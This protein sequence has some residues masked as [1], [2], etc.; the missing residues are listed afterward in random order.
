MKS[1]PI[2]FSGPMV[3]AILEG[4]K[5]QTRRIV[6]PQPE[7][8]YSL[9]DDRLCVIHN[10]HE[11]K[12]WSDVET[13]TSFPEQRLHGGR[14]WSDLFTDAICGLREKGLRGLV[15]IGRSQRNQRIFNGFVVP[16][17][18]ESNENGSSVGLHGVPR[19]AQVSRSRSRTW[20]Q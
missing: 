13:D 3:R 16:P 19:R 5:T 10:A 9:T 15:P 4:R 6:T 11:N 17:K 7:I 1:R 2:L 20:R 8:I 12:K 18:Q 14:G